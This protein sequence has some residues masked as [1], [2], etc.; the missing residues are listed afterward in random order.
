[1]SDRPSEPHTNPVHSIS[2]EVLVGRPNPMPLTCESKGVPPQTVQETTLDLVLQAPTPK[3]KHAGLTLS[4]YHACDGLLIEDI[5]QADQGYEAGLRKG[6]V[7]IAF[8]G[9]CCMTDHAA[10]C[11]LLNSRTKAITV[12]C[13]KFLQNEPP[14]HEGGRKTTTNVAALARARKAR[15]PVGQRKE[16]GSTSTKSSISSPAKG[17]SVSDADAVGKKREVI[18][19]LLPRRKSSRLSG[20]TSA[21]ETGLTPMMGSSSLSFDDEKE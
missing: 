2:V 1:M 19:P 21:S 17:S 18:E 8:D 3:N 10:A 5:V 13:I 7:I 11:K 16:R 4:A 14:S 15:S 6:D 9:V 20:G 12:R